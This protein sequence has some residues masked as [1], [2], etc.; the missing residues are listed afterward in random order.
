[1]KAIIQW[2][3]EEEDVLPLDALNSMPGASQGK[4]NAEEK[5]RLKELELEIAKVELERERASSSKE[6]KSKC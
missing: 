6:R 4:E 2:L 3:V 5:L 1:M